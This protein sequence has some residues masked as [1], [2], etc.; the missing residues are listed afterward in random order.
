MHSFL[1]KL[2]K[3]TLQF[4]YLNYFQFYDYNL[5]FIINFVKKRSKRVI[6][7]GNVLCAKN[8]KEIAFGGEKYRRCWGAYLNILGLLACHWRIDKFILFCFWKK[9]FFLC[10]PSPYMKVREIAVNQTAWV[11]SCMKHCTR[12]SCRRFGYRFVH[13]SR[14]A[15]PWRHKY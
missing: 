3:Q 11:I 5:I 10:D 1:C 4:I 9:N 8:G 6:S 15:E 12:L 2:F 7:W 13:S 14:R